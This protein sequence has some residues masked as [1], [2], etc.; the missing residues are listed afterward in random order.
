M[1]AFADSNLNGSSMISPLANLNPN[2]LGPSQP[3]L[4]TAGQ[5][6]DDRQAREAF[7]QFIGQT[8]YGQMIASLRQTVDKPA[9][10]HG[11]RAEEIFRK[12]LD[13]TM[14]EEMTR[15]TA[16]DFSGPMYELMMLQ[17]S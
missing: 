9:Y 16:G 6:Q 14:A 3:A 1:G 15:S 11:G 8:F 17:R 5:G 2:L 10:F 4:R 13:D 12:Q 7:D